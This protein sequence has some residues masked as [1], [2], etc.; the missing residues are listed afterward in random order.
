MGCDDPGL[1]EGKLEPYVPYPSLDPKANAFPLVRSTRELELEA[2]LRASQRLVEELE[3]QLEAQQQRELREADQPTK[4]PWPFRC[5]QQECGSNSSSSWTRVSS[6]PPPRHTPTR[7]IRGTSYDP[8]WEFSPKEVQFLAASPAK[9]IDVILECVHVVGMDAQ[10]IPQWQRRLVKHLGVSIP[11]SVGPSEQPEVF[12]RLLQCSAGDAAASGM[13]SPLEGRLF[14]LNWE[15]P[16]LYLRQTCTELQ[17]FVD[18]LPADQPA[19]AVLTDAVIGLGH[20]HNKPRLAFKVLRDP[21]MQEAAIDAWLFS[22]S[23]PPPPP[24]LAVAATPPLTRPFPP[25]KTRCDDS[26]DDQAFQL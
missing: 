10:S 3:F 25:D 24:A 17:L 20:C 8:F 18:G 23:P 6:S 15:P 1:L 2:Q 19:H 13:A 16:C 12:E 26:D 11:W 14:E 9:A 22:S 4:L 5:F 21:A 7:M